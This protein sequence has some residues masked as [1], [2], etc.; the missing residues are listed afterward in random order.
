MSHGTGSEPQFDHMEPRADAAAN[1]C[2][3][4]QRTIPDV[5]FE[6]GG[7]VFCAACKETVLAART[8]GSGLVRLVKAGILGTIAAGIS[9]AGWYG[10]V[11]LT[12]YELGIV[13]LVVGLFVGGAVRVGAEQRGGWLYQSLAVLLTYLAISMSYVP[14]VLESIHQEVEKEASGEGEADTVFA[15]GEAPAAAPGEEIPLAEMSEPVLL[16]IAIVG[17]LTIPVMQVTEGGFIGLLIV[18]FA[19]YEAWKLNKRQSIDFAGPFQLQR[20]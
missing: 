13:A 15:E 10:I 6:A 5:Y 1:A 19:L 4:C 20:G 7:K 14:L 11:K 17:S 3:A 2:A 8:G 16:T 9:A 18:C 12:G